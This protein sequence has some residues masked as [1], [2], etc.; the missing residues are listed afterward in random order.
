MNIER[1]GEAKHGSEREVLFSSLNSLQVLDGHAE[2][3]AELFLR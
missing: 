2:A 1:P 3:F